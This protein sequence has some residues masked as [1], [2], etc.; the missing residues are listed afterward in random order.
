MVRVHFSTS[1]YVTKITVLNAAIH[2][3]RLETMRNE[4]Q[5]G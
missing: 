3:G 5:E 1:Y 2:S 4:E